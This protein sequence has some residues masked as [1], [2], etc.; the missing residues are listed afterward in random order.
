MIVNGEQASPSRCKL[1]RGSIEEGPADQPKD[2]EGGATRK[3]LSPPPENNKDPVT[4]ILPR[5]GP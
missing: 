2:A 1:R 5:P 3:E 4:R